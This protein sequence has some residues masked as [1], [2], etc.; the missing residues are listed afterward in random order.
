[1][2]ALSPAATAQVKAL[3]L[4]QLSR[5]AKIL[6]FE[7]ALLSLQIAAAARQLMHGAYNQHAALLVAYSYVY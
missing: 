4:L 2:L 6:Q 7:T 3:L 5:R 1:M